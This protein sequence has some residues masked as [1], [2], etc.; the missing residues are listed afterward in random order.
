[1]A[2]VNSQEEHEPGAH[3]RSSYVPPD[4]YVP[5]AEVA[6]H[7]A[8]AVLVPIYGARQIERQ[9]PLTAELVDERWVVQGTL[10]HGARG[11]VARIEISKRDGRINHLSHGR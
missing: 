7:I 4:G 6:T 3:D 8:R 11:G 10:P 9:L 1:M 2:Q 5:T